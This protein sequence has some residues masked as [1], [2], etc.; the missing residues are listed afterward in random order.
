MPF[1]VYFKNL[2]KLIF[3]EW[4]LWYFVVKIQNDGYPYEGIIIK[5]IVH[6]LANKDKV[7]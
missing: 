6:W 5:D 3:L 1:L 7:S 4:M 2:K